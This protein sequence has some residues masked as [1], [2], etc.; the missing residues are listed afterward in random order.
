MKV[1]IVVK[2]VHATLV[3]S[4]FQLHFLLILSAVYYQGAKSLH[5]FF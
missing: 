4:D 1:G 3:K 2:C 5:V